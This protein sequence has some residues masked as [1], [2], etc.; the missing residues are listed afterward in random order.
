M[1]RS[2]PLGVQIF[3]QLFAGT[4]P[5]KIPNWEAF[6]KK[7]LMPEVLKLTLSFYGCIPDD[8]EY[9]KLPSDTRKEIRYPGYNYN[10]SY[11]RR[12]LG[13]YPNHKHLFK[14]IEK[15]GFTENEV[16]ELCCWQGT[17]YHRHQ[18]ELRNK[19][20][21]K[22]TTGDDVRTVAEWEH[23]LV[24]RAAL[25]RAADVSYVH[26]EPISRE[27]ASTLAAHEEEEDG[28]LEPSDADQSPPT[29][30]SEEEEDEEED[31]D[32]DTCTLVEALE[33]PS[34]TDAQQPQSESTTDAQQPQGEQPPTLPDNSNSEMNIARPHSQLPVRDLDP[35]NRASGPSSVQPPASD[36]VNQRGLASAPP[37]ARHPSR[38]PPSELTRESQTNPTPPAHYGAFLSRKAN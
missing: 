6:V 3:K 36:P 1:L 23:E 27:S 10:S 37:P 31:D 30:V 26:C 29:N 4:T 8:S 2:E 28:T 5:P 17:L 33:T 25:V 7:A 32:D 35:S 21:I 15:L 16:Y 13:P 18:Y 24:V 38:P 11:H 19:V 22:D 9:A 34:N 14:A 20:T 12:L